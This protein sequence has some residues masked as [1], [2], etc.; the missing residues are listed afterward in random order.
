M[1]TLDREILSVGERRRRRSESHPAVLGR[2][3]P[4]RSGEAAFWRTLTRCYS[5]QAC[6]MLCTCSRHVANAC[7]CSR[8]CCDRVCVAP[9]GARENSTAPSGERPWAALFLR[10]RSRRAERSSL[11]QAAACLRPFF[12]VCSGSW[13][14]SAP[15]RASVLGGV[16]SSG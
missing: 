11:G 2:L 3:H 12:A 16:L 7:C 1:R 14:T 15:L 4:R 5:A 6:V 9:R 13:K 8:H 10:R